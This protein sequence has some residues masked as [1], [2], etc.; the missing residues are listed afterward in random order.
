MEKEKNKSNQKISLLIGILL[1]LIGISFV[2]VYQI[3]R[4]LTES[5]EERQ[6]ES[7]YEEQ[8]TLKTDEKTITKN[9]IAVLN[10]PKIGLQKGLQNPDS[11]LNNVEYNIEILK[12][13]S[14][15]FSKKNSTI[16][17]AAHSGNSKVS[18]FKDLHFLEI[19]DEV[20][21]DYKSETYTYF[22][23]KIEKVLKTGKIEVSKSANS[24][25]LVL[26]TC[27]P[28]TDEQLVVTCEKI[29]HLL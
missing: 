27:I 13:S 11:W 5:I 16:F 6:L 24:N 1:I 17:L 25:I 26:I 15:D 18:Y 9:F 8:K 21:I 23:T 2:I 10:I 14:F 7:F 22:V 20:F 4:Q 28:K 29:A 12:G 19:N 3:D